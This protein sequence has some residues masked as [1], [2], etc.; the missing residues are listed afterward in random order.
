MRTIENV[1]EAIACVLDII[2]KGR[3]ISAGNIT[4]KMMGLGLLPNT[5]QSYSL[6]LVTLAALGAKGLVKRSGNGKAHHWR[7]TEDFANRLL[8]SDLAELERTNPD[9]ARAAKKL[10]EASKP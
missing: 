1:G 4:R 8:E 5:E 6:V 9:V 10:D 3:P 7:L 2:A